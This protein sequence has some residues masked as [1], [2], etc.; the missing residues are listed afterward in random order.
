MEDYMRCWMVWAAAWI[1]MRFA[2]HFPSG[3][4][5]K[6]H[7]YC[8]NMLMGGYCKTDWFFNRTWQAYGEKTSETG[9]KIRTNCFI[10]F[11][12]FIVP[13]KSYDRRRKTVARPSLPLRYDSSIFVATP[14]GRCQVEV[15]MVFI[16]LCFTTR[17]RPSPKSFRQISWIFS[18]NGRSRSDG[19]HWL[20]DW[21][22]VSIDFADVTLVSDDT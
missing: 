8:R 20:T 10:S 2:K 6:I 12:P 3:W 1:G 21:V 5:T 14:N 19:S 9:H 22:S 7:S 17:G 15:G 13:N 11:L 16:A 4:W 18:V